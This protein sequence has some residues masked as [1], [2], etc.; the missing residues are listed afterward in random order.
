MRTNGTWLRLI[1]ISG[2]LCLWTTSVAMA[3][4]KAPRPRPKPAG[5]ATKLKIKTFVTL[6]TYGILKIQ[7]QDR[8]G[9]ATKAPDG[10]TVT[11]R[12]NITKPRKGTL[13]MTKAKWKAGE[14]VYVFTG[15][16]PRQ[17]YVCPPRAYWIR[18][19]FKA[20]RKRFTAFKRFKFNCL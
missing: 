6:Q 13:P 14:K 10:G 17:R 12:T 1:A 20:G 4:E 8:K 11:Y 2:L 3:A 18:V 9:N 15:L 5:P 16:A 7:F 19:W